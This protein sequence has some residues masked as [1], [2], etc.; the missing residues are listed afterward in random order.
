MPIQDYLIDLAL[1]LATQAF[2]EHVD[3]LVTASADDSAALLDA[4]HRL[5][6]RRASGTVLGEGATFVVL[7]TAELARARG[8]HVYGEL[9][10][11]AWGNLPSPAHGFPPPR[12]RECT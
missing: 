3:A 10:G 7:E 1:E 12:R 5:F 2:D 8:A 4:A 9:A 11:T 6:D